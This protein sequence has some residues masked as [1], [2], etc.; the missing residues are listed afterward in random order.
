MFGGD[1]FWEAVVRVCREQW[2]LVTEAAPRAEVVWPEEWFIVLVVPLWQRKGN[3][4]DKNTWRELLFCQWVQSCWLG[5]WQL[6][7]DHP[8]PT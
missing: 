8:Y 3:K 7:L 6:G 5:L 2:L 1:K 4:K